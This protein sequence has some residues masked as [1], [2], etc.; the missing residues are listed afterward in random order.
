MILRH[1]GRYI[2]RFP[3]Y[4]ETFPPESGETSPKHIGIPMQTGMI[5]N[6]EDIAGFVQ[7]SKKKKQRS[8]NLRKTV[9]YKTMLRNYALQ[10]KMCTKLGQNPGVFRSVYLQI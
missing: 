10:Y 3:Q 7:M 2:F 9:N 5:H 1:H 4:L 8:L 6:F